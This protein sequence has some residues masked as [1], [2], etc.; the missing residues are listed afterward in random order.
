M[1]QSQKQEQTEAE[2]RKHS[3]KVYERVISAVE[4]NSGG[5]QPPLAKESSVLASMC[6]GRY[7]LESINRAMTAARSRGDLFVAK[8]RDGT[9]Y[10]GIDDRHRLRE[11]IATNLS[12]ADVVNREVIGLA[13][14][15]VTQLRGDDDE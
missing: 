13:N 1:S 7:D 4:H 14:N 3:K 10:L 9:R 11:K 8:T 12:V 2:R 5:R 6:C 15:R